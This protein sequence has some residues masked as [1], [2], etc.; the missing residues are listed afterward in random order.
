M[1]AIFKKISGQKRIQW[2]FPFMA[3]TVKVDAR[4]TLFQTDVEHCR[5]EQAGH[6]EFHGERSVEIEPHIVLS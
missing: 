4:I 5:L 1:G 2:T 3:H 6:H